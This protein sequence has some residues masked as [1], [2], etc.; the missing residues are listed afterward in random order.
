MSFFKSEFGKFFHRLAIGSVILLIISS[1][2]L[3]FNVIIDP[4]GVFLDHHEYVYFTNENN[5]R[6][7]KIKYLLKY[8][9]RNTNFIFG[10]SRV[11]F[12]NGDHFGDEKYFNMTASAAVPKDHLRDL[13]IMINGGVTVKRVVIGVDFLSFFYQGMVDQMRLL[14]FPYP[15]SIREHYDFYK[16]YLLNVPPKELFSEQ[17][18]NHEINRQVRIDNGIFASKNL[19]SLIL[20]DPYGHNRS[21]SLRIPASD[22]KN[23]QEF[24]AGLNDLKEL[25]NFLK[26]Q[27]IEY[28]IFVHATHV[29]TYLTLNINSYLEMLKAM[30]EITEYVDFSGLNSICINNLNFIEPSHYTERIGD[31]I[32]SRISGRAN[33]GLPDDFGYFIDKGNIEEHLGRHRSWI[34]DYFKCLCLNS[35]FPKMETPEIT[36]IKF[37]SDKE[38]LTKIDGLSGIFWKDTILV[39]A[40]YLRLTIRK[41]MNQKMNPVI[42]LDQKVLSWRI[43]TGILST[44]TGPEALDR[45]DEWELLIPAQKL[46]S[47]LHELSPGYFNVASGKFLKSTQRVRIKVLHVTNYPDSILA[48]VF[49]KP[50]TGDSVIFRLSSVNG[51]GTD[52]RIYQVN[53]QWLNLSGWALDA[54][55]KRNVQNMV[56]LVNDRM[57]PISYIRERFD[58]QE[59]YNLPAGM[60]GGWS[61]TVPLPENQDSARISFG[62]MAKNKKS[63]IRIGNEL[64]VLRLLAHDTTILDG[65]KKQGS[66][67]A[68]HIDLFNGKQNSTRWIR[69]Q[70]NQLSI[71]GWAVDHPARQTAGVVYVRIGDK[72]YRAND[73]QHRQDVA[74]AYNTPAYSNCGWSI[75]I[76][77]AMIGTGLLPVSLVIVT[78]DG[79]GYYTVNEGRSIIIE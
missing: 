63:I 7:G 5:K 35:Y 12:I 53:G 1:P 36:G 40:P 62:K 58:L 11:N 77:A 13:K 38:I 51:K 2:L 52:R 49:R 17:I 3:Y 27:Q 9:D 79:T 71:T 37:L 61:V 8:P 65:L 34:D 66:T 6:L 64:S 55:T 30:A 74:D 46:D 76:P 57:F 48:K 4:Y 33:P 21:M 45:K 31:L 10:S 78:H 26:S 32:I 54:T 59:R 23:P 16:N 56:I 68:T 72:L 44:P 18:K 60:F 75:E 47:G 24:G 20:S 70:G 22:Y 73:G 19:D 15:L 41:P 29:S 25:V 50:G 14:R 69:V 67:T 42:F 28:V 43:D 39:T